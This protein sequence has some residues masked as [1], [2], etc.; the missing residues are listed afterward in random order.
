VC[1]FL[2]YCAY[3]IYIL[4]LTTVLRVR[5]KD[6]NLIA[7]HTLKAAK[8]EKEVAAY[9]CNNTICL[10]LKNKFQ[11]NFKD[12]KYAANILAA[13]LEDYLAKEKEKDKAKLKIKQQ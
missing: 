5:N 1:S 9:T 4:P 7:K 2:L 13:A 12:R 8:R 10:T 6:L 11:F 3:E